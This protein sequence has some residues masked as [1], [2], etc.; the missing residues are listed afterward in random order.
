MRSTARRHFR[1]AP[2]SGFLHPFSNPPSPPRPKFPPHKPN[3]FL[4]PT[5][6]TLRDVPRKSG[7]ENPPL[8]EAYLWE[9]PVSSTSSKLV[10]L[11]RKTDRELAIMIQR[12]LER[13]LTLASVAATKTS[14]LHV[15]AD[16]IYS[17]METLL[18]ALD[19]AS[20]REQS[21]LKLKLRELRVAL[22]RVPA[23]EIRPQMICS[24]QGD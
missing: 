3:L 12:E 15:R 19:G 10:E 9:G 13:G 2:F 18:P 5:S 1:P 16:E 21:Q 11:R 4:P 20:Q 7:Y 24:A 17:K 8:L 6:N 23:K 22:D 14:P